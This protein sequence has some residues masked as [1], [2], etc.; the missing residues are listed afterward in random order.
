M[1]DVFA[2]IDAH[3][4]EYIELLQKFCRQPSVAA[5]NLGIREMAD[6]LVK[7]L[8]TVGITAEVCETDGNPIPPFSGEPKSVEIPEDIAAFTEELWNSLDEQ[9]RVSLF[10]RYIDMTGGE[11]FTK[12]INKEH[13]ND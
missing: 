1:K 8:A 4:Q 6:L 9:N 13:K 7:E 5:Q 3:A 12:I 10:V 11:S 2:Y